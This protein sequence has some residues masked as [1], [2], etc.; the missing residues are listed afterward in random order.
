MEKE[1]VITTT[2]NRVYRAASFFTSSGYFG[3]RPLRDGLD[4]QVTLH[5]LPNT[6]YI[7]VCGAGGN[8]IMALPKRIL[9]QLPLIK[10]D[11]GRHTTTYCDGSTPHT[12][13]F[14]RWEEIKILF[15]RQHNGSAEDDAMLVDMLM[16]AGA[17]DWIEDAEGWID[18]HGW[19]LIGPSF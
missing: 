12:A 8:G 14:L 5:P 18:E 6:D 1:K 9:N 16:L 7:E 4:A 10:L 11:E 19:G 2:W 15:G 3:L 17:P 13:I